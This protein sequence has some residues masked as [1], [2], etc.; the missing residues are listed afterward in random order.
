MAGYPSGVA[1]AISADAT[2][3]TIITDKLVTKSTILDLYQT[4]FLTTSQAT[5]FLTSLG[6]SKQSVSFLLAAAD[7]T[8]ALS[9]LKSAVTR[10]GS[11][12]IARKITSDEANASLLRLD[13]TPDQITELLRTWDIERTSN[14]KLPTESQIADA[15][16]YQIIDQ[17]TAQAKLEALGYTPYDAWMVLSVKNKAPLPNP[18]S[19]TTSALLPGG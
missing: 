2:Q 12:Y 6:Y 8:Y 10:I 13:L 4:K 3:Q 5:E 9:A 17:A 1:E 18:P 14:I 11:Y 16:E 15:W 19:Q 7:L